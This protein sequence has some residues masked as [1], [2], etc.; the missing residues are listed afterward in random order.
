M[1]IGDKVG[2]GLLICVEKQYPLMFLEYLLR[3]IRGLVLFG[4]LDQDTN[5]PRIPMR[6]TYEF[7]PFSVVLN[8]FN[9]R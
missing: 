5:S 3:I 1:I 4:L 2:S 7:K 6:M 9:E 8:F